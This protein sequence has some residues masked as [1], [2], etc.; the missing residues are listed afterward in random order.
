MFFEKSCWTFLGFD[1]GTWILGDSVPKNPFPHQLEVP[2]ARDDFRFHAKA[3][4]VPRSRFS[5][6]SPLFHS[7][8]K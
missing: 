4:V 7:V 5:P 8:E 3:S 2:Y 1:L 6:K